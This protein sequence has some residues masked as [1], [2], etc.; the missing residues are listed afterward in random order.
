M[1]IVA[2]DFTPPC[3]PKGYSALVT[4][5]SRK[6]AYGTEKG[7]HYWCFQID[8]ARGRNPR[9]RKLMWVKEKENKDT[10]SGYFIML[11]R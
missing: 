7:V 9:E 2:T 1:T 10:T 4:L 11:F 6:A 8:G 5:Q 3:M